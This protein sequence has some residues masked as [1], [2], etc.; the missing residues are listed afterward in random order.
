MGMAKAKDILVLPECEKGQMVRDSRRVG[1][2]RRPYQRKKN[3]SCGGVWGV[4]AR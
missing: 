1:T 4:E 3:C 2:V